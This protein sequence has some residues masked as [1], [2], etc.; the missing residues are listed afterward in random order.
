LFE[1]GLL[2]KDGS[3]IEKL[4]QADTVVFDKTGTLTS[5]HPALTNLR[6]VDPAALAIAGALA[7]RSR[8]P[9][10]LALVEAAASLLLPEIADVEEIAGHGVAAKIGDTL[11]R[12]GRR[13][14]ASKAEAGDAEAAGT[15]VVLGKDGVEMAAFR[16]EDAYRPGARQ[17][18]DA[19]K[20]LGL[21]I[22][23]LSGDRPSA[24]ARTARELGIDRFEAE[25]L[26]QHKVAVLER[27]SAEGHRVVMV[28]DGLNDA[29]ALATAHV[30][31]A[32]SSAADIGRQAADIVFTR[33]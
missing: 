3:A 30:S 11:Y 19:L 12:L 24:V 22:V 28:G 26:P 7:R 31:I 15:E 16:F 8:H 2:T 17:A 20:R 32:P 6:D 9:L 4:V 13:G 29:P 21:E 27:L 14:W 1:N 5:G 10:S 25:C 33:E 23:L 18:I